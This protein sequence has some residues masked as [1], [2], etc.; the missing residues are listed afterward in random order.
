MGQKRYYNLF[1]IIKLACMNHHTIIS[2]D[3]DHTFR[4][5]TGLDLGILALA[6]Y[7]NAKK[8][9]VGL[10]THR[11]LENTTL[12]TL[13]PWQYEKPAHNNDALAA[14]I[15]YWD[16]HLFQKL[17]LNFDFINA[18]YQ[19]RISP[20]NYYQEILY[21]LEKTLAA[22]ITENYILENKITIKEKIAQ[23]AQTEIPLADNECKEAQISWLMQTFSADNQVIY[24]IDD[25]PKVCQTLPLRFSSVHTIFYAQSPFFSNQACV[26]L[27]NEIGFLNDIQNFIH[28]QLLPED[29]QQC[30]AVILAILQLP[31]INNEIFSTIEAALNNLQLSS[32]SK[33]TYLFDFI[34]K[35]LL[36][37]QALGQSIHILMNDSVGKI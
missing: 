27:L 17:N 15:S 4:N 6:L 31:N 5:M 32:H 23:Y 9:P 2:I 13:Y 8:I 34:K 22:E 35:Q 33:L 7:A 11:D 26:L 3:W 14:A 20:A 25:D 21:P 1:K 10:T 18:R 28:S 24:H 29:P 37:V 19:S 12:Y 30:L 36:A 16:Q